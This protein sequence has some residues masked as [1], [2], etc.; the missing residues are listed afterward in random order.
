[1]I[2]I[3]AAKLVRHLEKRWGDRGD[4]D[5]VRFIDLAI[6]LALQLRL[7]ARLVQPHEGSGRGG[8]PSHCPLAA[9]V[10]TARRRGACR[11]SWSR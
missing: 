9:V 3:E 5:Y 1:M 10:I 7:P 11:T 8:A 6:D 2:A 4:P